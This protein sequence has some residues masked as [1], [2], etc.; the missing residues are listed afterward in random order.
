MECN[1][2]RLIRKRDTGGF[3]RPNLKTIYTKKLIMDIVHI[4]T[5]I[6]DPSN[7]RIE[8][9]VNGE[10][11]G[12]GNTSEM[13]FPIPYLIS[14]VSEVMTLYP[15]DVIPTGCPETAEIN[16]GDVVEVRIEGIG[17]LVNNV[18]KDY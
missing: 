7:L 14:W 1:S 2:S 13:I 10:L 8:C 11:S 6:D 16:V 17:S 12:S 4:Q 18:I 15:G 5:G 9:F 3:S